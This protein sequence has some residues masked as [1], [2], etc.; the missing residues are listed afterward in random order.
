MEK[1]K[2]DIIKYIDRI[3]DVDKL[4]RIFDYIMIILT[5]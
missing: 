1:L 2:A 3:N 5:Q 4:K